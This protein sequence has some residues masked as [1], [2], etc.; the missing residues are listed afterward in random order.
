MCTPGGR[1][2]GRR[3]AAV[4]ERSHASFRFC[5]SRGGSGGGEGISATDR[6]LRTGII[7]HVR[8]P[9]PRVSRCA[10][11]TPMGTL[12]SATWGVNM[13]FS[14]RKLV[15]PG[16]D[17]ATSGGTVVACGREA[18][19]RHLPASRGLQAGPGD[20]RRGFGREQELNHRAR[21]RRVRRIRA[22]AGG[23]RRDLLRLRWQRGLRGP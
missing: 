11:C 7:P 18:A 20:D 21:E 8:I 4:V 1:R 23:E 6:N 15:C 14:W 3:R 19:S 12:A 2:C 22:D 9:S 5:G 13:G 10:R 16:G 17:P